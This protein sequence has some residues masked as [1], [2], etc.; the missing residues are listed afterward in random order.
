MRFPLEVVTEV[1][2]RWPQNLPVFVRISA[3][4][5]ID[6]GWTPNDSILLAEKL[7]QRGVDLI[8]CSSGGFDGARQ[9]ALT[10]SH[11]RYAAQIAEEAL[12]PTMTAGLI[13]SPQQAAAAVE[14]H[15]IA[16]VGLAREALIDPNWP[17]RC[18]GVLE[19]H[20]IARKRWPKQVA[21]AL[22]SHVDIARLKA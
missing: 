14:E 13:R 11:I 6:G 9:N 5:H 21:W 19:G 1:R 15:G 8:D 20:K 17:L 10:A 2:R 3:T 12:I 7:K 4:D 18:S 16:L 22:E